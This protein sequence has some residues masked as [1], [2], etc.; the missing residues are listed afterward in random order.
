MS[1]KIKVYKF[2]SASTSFGKLH[3]SVCYDTNIN[4]MN[5]DGPETAASPIKST[6]HIS[7][8]LSKSPEKKPTPASSTI[9]RQGSPFPS[10]TLRKKVLSLTHLRV[11]TT[12]VTPDRGS[13]VSKEFDDVANVSPIS[14]LPPRILEKFESLSMKS[15]LISSPTK[16]PS[17]LHFPDSDSENLLSVSSGRAS[18]KNHKSSSELFGSFVGSYEVLF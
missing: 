11:N 12:T 18:H 14:P 3:L 16:A 15:K 9:K 6:P 8:L 4:E 13:S 7:R 2:K 10:P 1:A 17:F 5:D